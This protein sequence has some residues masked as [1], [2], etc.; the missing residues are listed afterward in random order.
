MAKDPIPI[1]EPD[2]VRPST[3]SEAPA[4]DVVNI[5]EPVPGWQPSP[6]PGMI[7]TPTP[8][9]V[10]KEVPPVGLANVALGT[11]SGLVA[12]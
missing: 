3:P 2:I 6:L 11:N 5:P 1:P 10:P 4:P 9:E 7:P 12:F 8:E